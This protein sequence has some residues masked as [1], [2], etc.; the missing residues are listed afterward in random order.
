MALKLN[1][2][3][4]KHARKLIDDGKYVLDSDWSEAQPSPDKENKFI[5]KEGWAAYG[6]WHLAYDPHQS[7][8]TKERY[9]FPFGDFKKVHR[10]ALNAVQQRAGQ[11]D[12]DE[13]GKEGDD[14][15]SRIDKKS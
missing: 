15:V 12:Y 8:E 11:Y 10:S 9:K 13:I 5:E 7:E 3:G 6:R 1:D 4:V 2:R 14:L